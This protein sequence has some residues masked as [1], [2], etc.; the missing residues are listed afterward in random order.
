MLLLKKGLKL[1]KKLE[2][3]TSNNPK[4]PI[5][6]LFLLWAFHQKKER[7]QMAKKYTQKG[8]FFQPE[9]PP[10]MEFLKV[11]SPKK[12]KPLGSTSPYI[13][14]IEPCHGCNLSCGHC[15]CAL[16]KKGVYHFMEEKTWVKTWEIIAELTPTCRIDLCLGGEPTL[17]K[18]LPEFLTIA[19]EI[20]PFSQI[21]I[22]T[23]G[24]MLIN[25]KFT[26][27]QLLDAGANIIYTDMYGPKEKFKKM[28]KDSGFPWYE[29]YNKPKGAPSPWTYFGPD[30]KIIV[31]QEQP[32]NWPKSRIRAGLLGTWY[33]NLDWEKA[34]RFNLYPVVNPPARR[35]NQ[36]FQYVPVDSRGNYLLCCQDN[37]GETS[38][39]FSSVYE[40]VEGFKKYWYSE[41]MQT[42]RRRLRQKDR[43]STSQCS[44]CNIT[45]SRCDFLHW[46]D[47]EVSKWWDGKTWHKFK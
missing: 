30:F 24:T 19:R 22:T 33:N 17:N 44:R 10:E 3:I 8:I 27:K 11:K 38:G 20:S 12:I 13:W 14:V 16:D 31:L 26:Y 1:P 37:T 25:K 32:E 2:F 40:G 5:V 29:Y 28:A 36:P 39:M 45:F 9:E 4:K 6:N 41:Y 42:V 15:S 43:V 7:I 47:K 46:T 23:N 34:K 35:C 18:N 21:Q